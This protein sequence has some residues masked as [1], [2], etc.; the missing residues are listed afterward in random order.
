MTVFGAFAGALHNFVSTWIFCLMQVI[1]FFLAF[2]IG[3]GLRREDNRWQA[4]LLV[5]L[6]SFT[7]FALVFS[8]IGLGGSAISKIL[9]ANMTLLTQIG[10]VV[11]GLAGLLLI[12]WLTVADEDKKPLALAVK[13]VLPLLFG[14]AVAFAYKPCVSPALTQIYSIAG[15]SA[16]AGYG[17][18]LLFSYASGI[19]LVIGAV[20]T[21]V[22][23]LI[24]RYCSGT[25]LGLARSACG[26]VVIILAVLVLS[27]NMTVYK[28]FLVGRF[29][30]AMD[31]DMDMDMEMA[32]DDM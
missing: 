11:I 25:L 28:S 24:N 14:A 29:A 1:P 23:W 5:T 4:S 30:P 20:G 16:T 22:T 15:N 31:M 26:V 17:W 7:G 9:F 2:I 12:G 32:H 27:G 10:A 19:G 8:S 21:G 3:S 6:L 18:L 13:F